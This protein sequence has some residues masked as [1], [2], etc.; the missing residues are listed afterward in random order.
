MA[1]RSLGTLTL[2][3]VAKI[4]GYT[5]GLDKAEKEAAKRAAAIQGAF[6]SAAIGVGVAFGAM[7]TAAAGAFAIINA[8]IEKASSF[9]DIADMTG[10]S[11][12]GFANFA[13]S[14]KVAGVEMNDIASASVKLTKALVGVDDESKAAGA[15]LAAI[16]INIEDFKKLRPDEQ[17]DA[18]AKA[19]GNFKEGAGKTAVALDLFGKSGANVL[20]FLKDY[21]EN[22][23]AVKI[24]TDEQ[25]KAADD[26]A[27]AQ[28]RARAQL[29]LYV[30]AAS[31]EFIPVFTGVINLAKEVIKEFTGLGGA[32]DDLGKNTG[33]KDFADNAVRYLGTV[34]DGI[35][36]VARG[37]D[38]VG[39]AI[40]ATAA[41]AGALA[42][43]EFK[44]AAGI[45]VD[46]AKDI[47][48]KVT[49]I[50]DNMISDRLKK[51][52]ETARKTVK[53]VDDA[54]KP[55]LNYQGV[56]KK[57]GGGGKDNSAAQEAKAQLQSDLADI[58]AAQ[59]AIVNTYTNAGKI[60][61]AQRSAGLKDEQE[62]YAEKKRLLI[63]S[64][65]AEQAG[66]QQQITRLQ[67]ENLTGKDAIDN[68][69]KI[70]ESQAKLTKARE[71]AATAVQVLAIQEESAYKKIASSLLAARQ[72]AQ[73]YFDTTNRGYER[74]LAAFGQGSV[75]RDI[76][77]GIQ[78]IEEK[79][80]QQRQDLANRRSQAELAAGGTLTAAVAKQ[81]DEQLAIIT[82]FESKSLAS[83][84]DYTN[85]K[86][87]VDNDW[88][89]GATEALQNYI[90]HANN[91]YQRA[92]EIFTNT[93]N[94]FDD[95]LTDTLLGKGGKDTWLKL[96]EDIGRQIVK[97]MV[98]KNVTAPLADYLQQAISGAGSGGGGFGGFLGGLFG[99]SS[100][101]TDVLGD[102][103]SSRGFASGGFT[104][105][106]NPN[107]PA[108]IVHKGEW[109][110]PAKQVRD[111]G[112]D[113]LRNGVGGF[114]QNLT[115]NIVGTPNNN[116]ATQI[117]QEARRRQLTAA[118]R[119]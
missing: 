63:A 55:T 98:Q 28:T 45:Q 29:E 60:L 53:A 46:A 51:A 7:A 23:G 93:L 96:G 90:D 25:I 9:Q 66:L 76:L 105:M 83:Y 1:S 84:K 115:V 78:Q 41:T 8:G 38:I 102:F 99:S 106:G 34:L 14:A 77:A 35:Q 56:P 18:V 70:T 104:G 111:I 79:Y 68:Q 82:E 49:T 2:D 101:S 72:S 71:D 4:G 117:A 69:R 6:D 12:E 73:D 103:I 40:G 59:D 54:T 20:K 75:Q 74:T 86:L 37:F 5:A 44:R 21:E 108:G 88:S 85:K 30:A 64:N 92:N 52:V 32:S 58:K 119:F 89:K 80:Q 61:E 31:T 65:D 57:T 97:G 94:G 13:V 48:N 112:V 39:T 10:G 17:I 19:L 62:Y 27:D 36:L 81:Y 118:A 43:G 26:Y 47:Y 11:A 114:N 113:N 16:G 50:G 116:T 107:E 109:V 91:A 42:Q 87:A 100:K 67:Q 33:V 95:A 110:I 22:G 3:L 15:A 24:L